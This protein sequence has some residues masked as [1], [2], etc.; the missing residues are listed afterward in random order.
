M[1]FNWENL[2]ALN[3]QKHQDLLKLH[4]YCFQTSL[5]SWAFIYLYFKRAN[6]TSCRFFPEEK[7]MRTQ[8]WRYWNMNFGT[9][10]FI[11]LVIFDVFIVKPRPYSDFVS[12][13]SCCRENSKIWWICFYFKPT[14]FSNSPCT[15]STH[16]L[17]QFID[18]TLASNIR[19]LLS[20]KVPSGRIHCQKQIQRVFSLILCTTQGLLRKCIAYLGSWLVFKALFCLEPVDGHVNVIFSQ[21]LQKLHKNLCNSELFMC[22]PQISG[23]KSLAYDNILT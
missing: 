7:R 20:S 18:S 6:S 15:F 9:K 16:S 10:D 1:K 14:L 3:F 12:P 5:N 2:T 22:I 17:Q 23:I 8:S 13:Q 19:F 11:H 21:F 4:R